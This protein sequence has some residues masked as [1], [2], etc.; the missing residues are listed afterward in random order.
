MIVLNSVVCPYCK[1]NDN[2]CSTLNIDI[3][4]VKGFELSLK[5]AYMLP[6]S[7]NWKLLFGDIVW[8]ATTANIGNLYSYFHNR[9][10][11]SRLS[12]NMHTQKHTHTH[13]HSNPRGSRKVMEMQSFRPLRDRTR[14]SQQRRLS[15]RWRSMKMQRCRASSQQ[16]R[17]RST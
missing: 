12:I 8:R 3:Q 16:S 17:K 4:H 10:T 2:N 14:D 7:T 9:S 5:R 1:S 15:R 11:L 6:T 13:T